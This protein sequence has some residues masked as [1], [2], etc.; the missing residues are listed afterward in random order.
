MKD[1]KSKV[2]VAHL[3]GAQVIADSNSNL[4]ESKT[5]ETETNYVDLSGYKS[6]VV[7]VNIGDVALS[8][9]DNSL[10]EF[11]LL[12]TDDPEDVEQPFTTVDDGDLI[13]GFSPIPVLVD[14]VLTVIDDVT[15]SVGY[16]GTKRYIKA[17]VTYTI[18]AATEGEPTIPSTISL[19]ISIDAILGDSWVE[20][21]VEPVIGSES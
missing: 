18:P 21:T 5:V 7:I 6:A 4:L 16:I 8:D 12:E 15:Q 19:P 2:A 20:P 13:G 17:K 9:E 10:I 3:L 11:E 14:E 1:L